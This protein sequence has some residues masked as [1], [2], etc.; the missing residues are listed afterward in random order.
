[1]RGGPGIGQ[2]LLQEASR[3]HRFAA[4]SRW[5]AD[6]EHA[7]DDDEVAH[8]VDHEAD[9]FS[10]RRH[11]QTG[12]RR[13]DHARRV[14]HRGIQPNGRGDIGARDE[15]RQKRLPRGH[16]ND[17]H[18]SHED[19]QPQNPFDR[20]ASAQGQDTEQQ[21]LQRQEGVRDEQEPPPGPAIGD[22]AP[23]D[24]EEEN[25]RAREEF[26]EAEKKG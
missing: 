10:R 5:H 24:A 12:R 19:R 20:D 26:D 13:P 22:R 4:A 15:I 23:D 6:R 7:A 14:E 18:Q 11:D 16:F 3:R 21:G 2:P 25:G 1:M 17:A 9:A 8:R